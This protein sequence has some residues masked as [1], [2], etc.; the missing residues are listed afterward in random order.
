MSRLLF[1]VLLC[2][3]SRSALRENILDET[4]AAGG[5]RRIAP[6]TE[7]AFDEQFA[8]ARSRSLS[9]NVGGEELRRFAERQAY[10][11]T[12]G[13]GTD[14]PDDAGPV[15]DAAGPRDTGDGWAGVTGGAPD[16]GAGREGDSS[17]LS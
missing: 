9:A 17:G 3:Y 14:G 4:P 16:G 6:W 10:L 12:R 13:G 2:C 5:F 8:K 1:C 15:S 11:A 7:S